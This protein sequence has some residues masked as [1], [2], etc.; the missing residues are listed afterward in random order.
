MLASVISVRRVGPDDG[1]A[2]G[3]P[4]ARGLYERHGFDDTGE[5]GGLLA[6]GVRR[7]Q[8]MAERLQR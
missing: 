4:A 1:V 2:A 8:V 6:D 7:E 5:R 3:N